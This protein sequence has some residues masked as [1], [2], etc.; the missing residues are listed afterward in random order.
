MNRPHPHPPADSGDAEPELI[1]RLRG[2]DGEQK[3]LRL[4]AQLAEIEQRLAHQAGSLQSASRMRQIEAARLAV[5]NASAILG[6]IEIGGS[7]DP[8]PGPPALQQLFRS[9]AHDQ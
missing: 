3:R 7:A 1:E 6:R 8:S 5:Q 4:I 2:P 9:P